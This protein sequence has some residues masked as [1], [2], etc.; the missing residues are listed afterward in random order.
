[1]EV[2]I[3]DTT[4]LRDNKGQDL[5]VV[6]KKAGSISLS[7]R[8]ILFSQ[9]IGAL[10]GA[11]YS[12]DVKGNLTRI[13]PS[14]ALDIEGIARSFTQYKEQQELKVNIEPSPSPSPGLID[15]QSQSQ[16]DTEQ[17]TPSLK[18][19]QYANPQFNPMSISKE[20]LE[21]KA[22]DNRELFDTSTAQQLGYED[23][24]KMKQSGALAEQI[25]GGLITQSKTFDS[26][27]DFSKEKY[28]KKKLNKHQRL[29]T[30]LKPTIF[31]L[32]ESYF[33]HKPEKVGFMRSDLLSQIL[34]LANVNTRYNNTLSSSNTIN[35]SV[36]SKITQSPSLLSN[37][38]QSYTN[39]IVFD[40]CGG[41]VIASMAKQMGGASQLATLLQ[42]YSTQQP[43]EGDASTRIILNK[44]EIKSIVPIPLQLFD[45]A[46]K[47]N[48]TAGP[49]GQT[50][51]ESPAIALL[52]S[53][54]TFSFSNGLNKPQKK[55][56]TLKKKKNKK[57]NQE[58]KDKADNKSTSFIQIKKDMI[59][60]IEIDIKPKQHLVIATSK[61]DPS[62][63][64]H[65]LFPFLKLSGSFVI[66][67]PY[68]QILTNLCHSIRT[69]GNAVYVELSE[70]V[71]LRQYQ[72]LPD[73]T[74]PSVESPSRGGGFILSG[75]KV[76]D[77]NQQGD[78]KVDEFDHI[79]AKE[80]KDDSELKSE[81]D[82]SDDKEEKGQN[83]ARKRLRKT[84]DD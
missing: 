80:I 21:S 40:E 2:Q 14:A 32:C 81:S 7:K 61:H 28:I 45:K 59:K 6:V 54:A 27:T 41:I 57:E 15:Q 23:I 75:I 20:S 31:L 4:L 9:L 37:Q 49:L 68:L 11:T 43:T 69:S 55:E 17:T 12:I 66:Y 70:S 53:S 48:P 35:S 8:T 83:N 60:D 26:K 78:Q 24:I 74:H 22:K 29:V 79:D 5:F 73:R 36:S 34:T 30:I 18:I 77:I 1:M 50:P 44:D 63:I 19:I 39:A 25:V 10:Y 38:L 3:G 47:S 52:M 67:S 72:I 71:L 51:L 16:I 76:G 65:I 58:E 56:D 82:G 42:A 33:S 46:L 13:D 84:E 64:F 62:T